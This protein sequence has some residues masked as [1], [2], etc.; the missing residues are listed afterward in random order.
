M[1]ER[2]ETAARESGLE[3]ARRGAQ[4]GQVSGAGG[5]SISAHHGRGRKT[6][7]LS[8]HMVGYRGVRGECAIPFWIVSIFSVD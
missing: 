1:Q 7:H 2:D 4:E 5:S 6:Q 3:Q 8:A